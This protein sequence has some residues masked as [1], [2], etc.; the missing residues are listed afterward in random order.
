VEGSS[1]GGK[2]ISGSI[3]YWGILEYSDWRLLEKDSA[4]WTYAET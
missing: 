3:K 2:E 4:S 1:D